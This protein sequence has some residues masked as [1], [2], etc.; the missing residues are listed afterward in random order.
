MNDCDI[1]NTLSELTRSLGRTPLDIRPI[2][3][4]GSSRKYFRIGTEQGSLIGTYNANIEENEAFFYLTGHFGVQVTHAAGM[5]LNGRHA[6]RFLDFDRIHVAVDIG[7]HNRYAQ[8]ILEQVDGADECS[9]L[10]VA[11]RRHKIQQINSLCF[12]IGAQRIGIAVVVREDALL[13]FDDFNFVHSRY[14]SS[15]PTT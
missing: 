1:Q 3:E 4:S 11:G 15:P 13:Y 9:S 5:Q 12:E 2:A 6:S 8:L 10:A 7:L 14:I